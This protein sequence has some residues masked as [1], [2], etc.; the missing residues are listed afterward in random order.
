[1]LNQN[2]NFDAKM[3]FNSYYLSDEVDNFNSM[4]HVNPKK[5]YNNLIHEFFS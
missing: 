2:F 1:M 5:K 4:N 3:R